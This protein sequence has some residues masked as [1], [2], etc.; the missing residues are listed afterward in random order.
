MPPKRQADPRFQPIASAYVA[1]CERRYGQGNYQWDGSDGRA[2]N[3]LLRRQPQMPL[4]K[5]LAMIGKAFEWAHGEEFCPLQPGFRFR[6][7]CA[8]FVKIVVHSDAARL[9][10][11]P[12]TKVQQFFNRYG[13]EAV[14]IS[15]ENRDAWWNR[16]CQQILG[17]TLKQAEEILRKGQ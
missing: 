12:A 3:D 6:E 10:R 13:G 5:A 4:E 9:P 11:V 16:K 2:L 1:E 17:I 7:F 14:C 15:R 8:H